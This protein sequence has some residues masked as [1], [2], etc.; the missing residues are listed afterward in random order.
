[1]LEHV[2]EKHMNAKGG[3]DKLCSSKKICVKLPNNGL[4]VIM[5]GTYG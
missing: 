4:G 3:G 5:H 2:I 1:M